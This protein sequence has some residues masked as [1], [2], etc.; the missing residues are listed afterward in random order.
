MKVGT[1]CIVITVIF[2]YAAPAAAQQLDP[3]GLC[4]R[5]DRA[6]FEW[7][8]WDAASESLH[9]DSA[10]TLLLAADEHEGALALRPGRARRIRPIGLDTL[11]DLAADWLAYS[12]WQPTAADTIEV[13]WW[14]GFQGPLFRL[15]VAGDTLRGTVV[16]ATD[17]VIEGAEPPG[18]VPALARR[19]PCPER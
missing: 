17:E 1:R 14:E 7:F 15:H 11:R 13:A 18:P 6:W 3:V 5:F 10:D 2:G 9:A 16:Y 8:Y 19:V 12:Y 4:Y